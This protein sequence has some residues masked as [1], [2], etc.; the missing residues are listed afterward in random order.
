MVLLILLIA[1]LFLIVYAIKRKANPVPTPFLDALEEHYFPVYRALEFDYIDT[2]GVL[3]HRL[4]EVTQLQQKFDTWYIYAYCTSREDYRTFRLDRIRHC[5]DN[6]VNID[7]VRTHL[8]E[9]HAAQLAEYRAS[10]AFV[11]DQLKIEQADALSIVFYVAKADGRFSAAEKTPVL[12]FLKMLSPDD[13]LNVDSVKQLF[14]FSSV[15]T[16]AEFTAAVDAIAARDLALLI[17]VFDTCQDIVNTQPTVS[18]Q[19]QQALDYL[20]QTI[21]ALPSKTP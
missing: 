20:Q 12:R 4:V 9:K 5:V 19:E 7:D 14:K 10:V 16:Y 21:A 13:R 18:D 11:L 15:P 17:V 3:T 2:D 8:L 6:G 1:V